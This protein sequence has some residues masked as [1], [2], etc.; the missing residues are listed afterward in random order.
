M[1][2]ARAVNVTVL[3][4]AFITLVHCLHVFRDV[5]ELL[6]QH[7][8]DAVD[9]VLLQ[10]CATSATREFDSEC[11]NLRA[12]MLLSVGQ[13]HAALPLVQQLYESS[14]S[15]AHALLF[16]EALLLTKDSTMQALLHNVPV[17]S[18]NLCG[19]I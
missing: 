1:A 10:R 4:L 13:A 14:Q 2:I 8:Y 15:I 19:R 5:A 18:V 3:I 7:D 16:A 17:S 9:A 11:L 6:E 12:V